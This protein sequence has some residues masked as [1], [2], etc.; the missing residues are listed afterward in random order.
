MAWYVACVHVP[1]WVSMTALKGI[2][3]YVDDGM[4]ACVSVST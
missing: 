1:A 2:G 3:R 4:Y